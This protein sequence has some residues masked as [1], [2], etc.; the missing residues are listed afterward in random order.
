MLRAEVSDVPKKEWEY[1]A[2]ERFLAYL[3]RTKGEEWKLLREDY[4]VDGQTGKDFDFQLGLDGRRMAL[5]LFR[6]TDDG[7]AMAAQYVWIEIVTLIEKEFEA[8]GIIGLAMNTPPYFSVPK[9]QRPHF[10]RQICDK[11]EPH[12]RKLGDGEEISL[13][14]FHITKIDGLKGNVS[15]RHYG[16]GV[17]NPVGKAY[18][19]I[20]RLLPEK[21]AQLN[22]VGHER[23]VL[24]VSWA[25]IV[26]TVDMIEALRDVDLEPLSNIDRIYFEPAIDQIELVF[27]RGSN[28]VISEHERSRLAAEANRRFVTTG[29]DIK[30]V[31]GTLE[32]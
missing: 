1:A 31:Y 27:E 15:S 17:F 12:V 8:R 21:N 29:I 16:F 6:L 20:N 7:H 24:I 10:A 28:L 9:A 30:D 5:E 26:T 2:K 13:D 19:P 11:L 25:H 18:E 3:K 32:K 22:I 23:T 14:R 4:Q